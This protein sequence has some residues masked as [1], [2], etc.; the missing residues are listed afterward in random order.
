MRVEGSGLRVQGLGFK[1]QDSG[2]RVQSSGVQG[3][4][5]RAASSFDYSGGLSKLW[6]LLALRTLLRLD[7]RGYPKKNNFNNRL[8]ISIRLHHP[9]TYP[10]LHLS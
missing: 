3:L 1:V 4:G 6:P 8:M 9:S 10:F 5:L 7:F 2:F